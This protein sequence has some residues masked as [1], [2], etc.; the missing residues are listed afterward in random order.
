MPASIVFGQHNHQHCIDAALTRAQQLCA[1]KQ[2]KLTPLR[3]QV[4]QLIWQSHK[5][6]G[7]YALMAQLEA[8]TGKRVA[9]P[10]VYRALEF[11]LEQGL[12]HRVHSLN[13]YMGCNQP[14]HQQAGGLFICQSCGLAQ[15][16]PAGSLAATLQQAATGQQF[17][18][19]HW[20]LEMVGQCQDCQQAQV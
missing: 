18:L 5:P 4:F 14:G 8:V 15:E 1:A 6:L 3:M 16:L 2:V 9:P 10:T 13:A 11:L 20:V 17:R 12:I 19:S 7:A